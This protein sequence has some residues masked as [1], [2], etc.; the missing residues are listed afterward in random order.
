MYGVSDIMILYT[1]YMTY[2]SSVNKLYLSC[3]TV[4]VDIQN[5][6]K[7]NLIFALQTSPFIL[8][9]QQISNRKCQLE[10][11]P[12]DGVAI[13]AKLWVTSDYLMYKSQ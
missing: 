9:T 7:C 6:H 2:K 5:P 3:E 13:G 10:R 11:L 4:L 12:W 1:I 8:F